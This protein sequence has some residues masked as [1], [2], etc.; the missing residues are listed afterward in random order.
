MVSAGVDC[1]VAS[2]VY[3]DLAQQFV[4]SGLAYHPRVGLFVFE[5]DQAVALGVHCK[6]RN[7]DLS[8]EA[9]VLCEVSEGGRV[10]RNSG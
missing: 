9:D 1:A 7:I 3:Q 10:G 8:I 5:H 2:A 6:H 4:V